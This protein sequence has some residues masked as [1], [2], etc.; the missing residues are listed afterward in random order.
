MQEIRGL[1]AWMKLI[2]NQQMPALDIVVQQICQLDER[3][4]GNAD[5]LAKIVLS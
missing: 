5:D 1:Q 2:L 3:N 4:E